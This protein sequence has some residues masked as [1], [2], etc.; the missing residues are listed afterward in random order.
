MHKAHEI[1][2]YPTKSQ[3]IFFRKSCGV[4][5]FAYNW[6]LNNW[7]EKYKN[8]EKTSAYSLI[9]EL[10]LIKKE[11]FPWMQETGKCASQYAIHNVEKAFKNF[12]KK[13]AKCP[14]FKKKGMRDSFIA[15]ENNASFNN[16]QKDFKIKIP[17][18]GWV[19]C[20]EN[21]RFEGKVNNVCI[22]RIADKWFAVVNIEIPNEAPMVCENQA[23][24][25]VD[26]GIKTMATCSNGLVFENPKAL[27][28]NLKRLKRRQKSLCRKIKGSNNR[29]KQQIVVAK[30]YYRIACIRKNAIHNATTK[31]VDSASVIVM[32]DLNVQGMLKN[33]KLAQAIG[34]VSFGEFLRQIKYKARWQ[35]KE[36]VMA[37]RFYASSKTCSCCGRKKEVLKLSER[38][39]SCEYCGIKIDRDLNAAKN[40]ANYGTTLKF[41]ESKAFGVGSFSVAIQNS[42]TMKKEINCL[43][44]PILIKQNYGLE[45]K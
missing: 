42:P 33:R 10:N 13:N 6:A 11:D 20:S 18:L 32:E 24:V 37:D 29:N 25:G 26:L 12:F 8:G 7:N 15:I 27:R 19:K 3:E 36:V 38:I 23:I 16:N 44:K 45:V 39:F 41:S 21:L 4:S 30:T 14:K 40:L 1:R 34:D 2:L 5:R 31:I 22:K 43:I 9:K 17:R 35:N 28:S